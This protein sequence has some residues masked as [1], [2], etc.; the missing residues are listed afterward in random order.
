M[1]VVR[2][3]ISTVL[4]CMYVV[5]AALF[6][7]TVSPI[8]GFLSF[9][10]S[11]QLGNKTEQA[12]TTT[13]VK[14]Q[15]AVD[16]FCIAMASASTYDKVMQFPLTDI[17]ARCKKDH[18]YTDEDMELLER[19]LRKFL[20]LCVTCK[21]AVGMYSKD[22]DNLWHTFILFTH[23]YCAFSTL[24]NGSYIHHDPVRENNRPS[25]EESWKKASED[26][27]QFIRTYEATFNQLI[28]PIWLLDGVL[29]M[30]GE[31]I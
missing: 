10:G 22:V 18:N 25:T 23:E 20:Y 31:T 7:L 11:A 30:E 15:A 1:V 8:D 5:F 6:L 16:S 19:E 2:D 28:D 9:F 24:A 27:A 17:V 29:Q 12:A 14:P 3:P 4:F 21:D 26:Y 13:S